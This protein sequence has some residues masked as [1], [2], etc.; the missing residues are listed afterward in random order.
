MTNFYLASDEDPN[1]KI[2]KDKFCVKIVQIDKAKKLGYTNN[3][4]E[5]WFKFIAAEN[6]LERAKIAKGDDLL[7]ALNEWIHKYIADEKTQE[8][9]NKWDLEIAE[10]KGYEQGLEKALNNEILK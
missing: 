10:N 1:I 3:E 4:L 9:L 5:R 6:E 8:E 7:V 2:L